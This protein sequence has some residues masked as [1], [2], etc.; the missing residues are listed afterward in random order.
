MKT[1]FTNSIISIYFFIIS[2]NCIAQIPSDWQYEWP[3]TDFSQSSIEFSEVMSGGPPKDG[4]PAIDN[5][6]FTTAINA[7]YIGDSEPVI[8]LKIGDHAKAYPFRILM[9]HEIVNDN[10]QN[11]P[12]TVTYCPL[13]NAAVVFD[14]RIN[15]KLLD[16]GVTGKLRHSDMIM[17]DRQTQSWWQQFLGLGIVG[18]MKG[19]QLK[20]L[21]ARVIPF[22]EFK[23]LYPNGK[24]LTSS[25]P[26]NRAYGKNPYQQYDSSA[27]PFLYKGRYDGPG[28][29]MSYVI[30]V[31][32]KAW[33]LSDLRERKQILYEDIKI[34]WQAGMNSALDMSSINQGRDLGYVS[35]IR[36]SANDEFEDIS[37]DM[38]FA[39]VFK[40]FHPNGEIHESK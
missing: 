8:F 29:P 37:Y 35:V 14:R 27:T 38:T 18:E 23:R 30:S 32:K 24:I 22:S 31:D 4:M 15:G 9:W 6:K 19:V 17:Y 39:F 40:A 5:P 21:P 2:S 1:C 20:R 12:V 16:F 10:F 25:N 36:K 33:L 28:S 13:C 7:Q 26:G 34:K 11:I 3:D